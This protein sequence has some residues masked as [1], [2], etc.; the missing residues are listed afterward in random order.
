M[1]R[2][3]TAT[4]LLPTS[5]RAL[6][7]AAS[8]WVLSISLTTQA[9]SIA[10]FTGCVL[11]CFAVDLLISRPPLANLRL[12]V[13]AL[14]AVLCLAVGVTL[15][16]GLTASQAFAGLVGPLAAYETG[17]VLEWLIFSASLTLVLRCLAHRTDLGKVLEIVFVA[18]AF[19]ITLAAHR[20]GMI[21]RPFFIGD[22]ALSRGIDPSSILLAFGCGA[23]LSLSALL[24]IEHNHRRLPYHFTVLGLLCFSLLIYVQFFGLPTPRMTD[25]LGLTGTAPAGGSAQDENPFRDGQNDTSDMQTPVAVVLFR[26]DYEPQGGAYYFRESAYSQFNGQLLVVPQREDMDEDLIDFFTPTRTEINEPLP[27]PEL[28]KSVRITVGM[29]APHRTPFGLDTPVAYANTPNPNSLRFKQTY[30]AYSLVPQYDF[31]D[32]IGRRSGDPQWTAEQRQA[33]LQL[34]ADPRYRQLA[35]TILQDLRP[36]FA[37]DP[38]AKAL[39]IKDYLDRKGIYSLKNEHAYAEDPAASFLFGDLTG[40]CMH[41]AFAAT[42]MYRSIGLPARVG[43]G[44]SVPASNRAG[45]SSLLVQ[46]INGHAWPEIYLDGVGWIIVDP[47]PSRTLVDMSVDPQNSL[48]QLLGDML[49]DEASFD[50]F[51]ESQQDTT[52]PLAAMLRA[53]AGVMLALLVAAYAV[54]LYRQRAP[55]YAQADQ[56]YRLSYRAILDSLGA[57]G[58]RRRYGESRESFARRLSAMTPSFATMTQSHLQQAMRQLPGDAL[59][60]VDM[61]EDINWL[62]L[63]KQIRQEVRQHIPLWRRMLAFLNPVSWLGTH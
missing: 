35:E 45:G 30:D 54:K 53:L 28:R 2:E 29:L 11:A 36:E 6:I 42:Y 39:A 57:M 38:Y 3:A 60:S 27:S 32:L 43:I 26:D 50:E 22:F 34:P 21:H 10:A 40:Y 48:Q 16:N 37:D 47:A 17:E 9:G 20:Q 18:S 14:L 5:L 55:Y 4:Q 62:A 19:V 52:L 13:I 33:Y 1:K 41:F 46:A 31:S 59:V 49:R 44:Y 12:G 23:V 51:I 15:A 61:A 63:D 7:I 56:R 24:M 8:Y 25:D 58:L